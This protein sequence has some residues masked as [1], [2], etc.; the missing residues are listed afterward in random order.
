MVSLE[1]MFCADWNF[2]KADLHSHD[3]GVDVVCLEVK[4]NDSVS[5]D[6]S[7]YSG[8]WGILTKSDGASERGRWYT[9]K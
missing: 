7:R 4:A 6:F 9:L 3:C 2:T 5:V 8:R 1:R